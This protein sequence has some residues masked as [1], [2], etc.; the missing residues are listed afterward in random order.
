MTCEHYR[1]N[2]ESFGLIDPQSKFLREF[3]SPCSG[4]STAR[5][6]ANTQT[7]S[8]RRL[9]FRT[10]CCPFRCR[11]NDKTTEKPILLARSKQRCAYMVPRMSPMSIK[12]RST[13]TTSWSSS[14]SITG[15]PL[16]IVAIDILSG[17][18]LAT[19][20]SKYIL[21]A[22]DYLRNGL[23]LIHY[24]MPKHILA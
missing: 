19:D 22:T 1:S 10:T 12:Q 20:G 4:Q 5:G 2:Q 21:V 24:R 7:S 23:K 15:E 9:P 17:L 18:P 3:S 11:A 13:Y 16:D 8:L 14:K 6:S